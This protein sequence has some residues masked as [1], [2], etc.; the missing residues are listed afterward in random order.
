MAAVRAVEQLALL[1][2][3][4]VK[5]VASGAHRA[6][7]PTQGKHGR[8]GRLEHGAL[9]Q[10]R[11][12]LTIEPVVSLYLFEHSSGGDAAMTDGRSYDP[13]RPA[14]PQQPTPGELR[15]ARRQTPRR[16][17]R[18]G[19]RSAN[20]RVTPDGQRFLI[21]SDGTVPSTTIVVNWAAALKN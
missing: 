18:A 3:V 8:V 14:T 21:A 16:P 13:F 17:L 6:Q 7:Q 11:P 2:R 12:S 5:N 20:H 19:L 9:P 4:D 15:C 10:K 1:G